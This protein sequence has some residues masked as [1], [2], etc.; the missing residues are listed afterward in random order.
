MGAS[1]SVSAWSDWSTSSNSG[2]GDGRGGLTTAATAPVTRTFS[3]HRRPG[4]GSST[5]R[6][7]LLALVP[8]ERPVITGRA[9]VTL[10]AEPAPRVLNT[11]SLDSWPEDGRKR[12]ARRPRGTPASS[13]RQLRQRRCCSRSEAAR[14]GSREPDGLRLRGACVLSK[15]WWPVR[16]PATKVP[17]LFRYSG[18]LWSIDRTAYQRPPNSWAESPTRLPGWVCPA[19]TYNGSRRRSPARC[20]RGGASSTA[21][22]V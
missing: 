3:T 18:V 6:S 10:L 20:R 4:L 2:G 22:A 12:R 21:T 17:R 5:A 7:G 11:G 8:W 14:S 9:G 1:T 16:P 19:F 13:P 15:L